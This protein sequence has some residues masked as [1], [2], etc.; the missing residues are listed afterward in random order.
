LKISRLIK[1][2][3]LLEIMLYIMNFFTS[4]RIITSAFVLL[5]LFNG[6]LLS[7]LWMQNTPRP[8]PPPGGRQFNHDNFF[9][10]QLDLNASQTVTFEKLRQEHFLKVSPEIESIASLKKQLVVESLK[11]KPDTKTTE[12]IVA[13][14]GVHHAAIERE[15]VI[16]FHQLTKLCTPEQKGRLKEVL[17]NMATRKL[18]HGGRGRWGDA[19]SA[20]KG[21]CNRPPR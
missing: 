4:K 10:R 17:E 3:G 5:V 18:H 9:A 13:S 2:D 6:A 19:P 16:H 15:Q 7:V 20:V 12:S 1:T 11:D 21:D 14:I 8:E